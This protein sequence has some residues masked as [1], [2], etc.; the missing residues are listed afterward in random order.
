[1]ELPAPEPAAAGRVPEAGPAAAFPE[2]RRALRAGLVAGC[3]A[4]ALVA[5]W[6]GGPASHADGDPALARLL[7]GMAGLKA[8]AVLGIA[9]GL[10]WRFGWPVPWRLAAA[11]AVGTWMLAAASVLVW[12]L[13]ELGA[14]AVLFHAGLVLLAV[15]GLRDVGVRARPGATGR[16]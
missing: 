8:A 10:L 1:V 9:A 4:A 14:A 5:G 6:L 11:Y 13:S 7:R 16:R 3:L 12:R 15:A 2:R